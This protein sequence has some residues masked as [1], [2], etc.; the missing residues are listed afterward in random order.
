MM[1]LPCAKPTCRLLDVGALDRRPGDHMRALF[2]VDL[3]GMRGIGMVER[4][5]I[6]VLRMLGQMVA[7]G[8]RQI[9]IDAIWH[10]Q[11]LSAPA[12]MAV[13]GMLTANRRRP[14]LR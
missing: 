6:D 13:A 2:A 11:R 8:R 4:L 14:A 1:R 12:G 9:V 10:G 5:A 7:H 3:A